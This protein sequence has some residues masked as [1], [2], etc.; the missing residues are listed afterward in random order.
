M[1]DGRKHEEAL[2][3]LRHLRQLAEGLPSN[4]WVQTRDLR[5]LL[6][7]LLA[8]QLNVERAFEMLQSVLQWRQQYGTWAA[9]GETCG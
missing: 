7:F 8:R 4:G 1:P 2:S 6:R 9:T 3:K 5:V